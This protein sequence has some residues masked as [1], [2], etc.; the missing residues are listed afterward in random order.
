MKLDRDI[1][2]DKTGKYM[3]IKQRE[4]RALDPEDYLAAESALDVLRDLGVLDDSRTGD[5][6]E[7]FVMRLKDKYTYR[8]LMGYLKAIELEEPMDG[9]YAD[10]ILDMAQRAG[11]NSP[12]CKLPD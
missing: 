8:G 1:N 4:L 7:F 6:G 5:E 3:L 10:A 12:F 11:V 2:A 9:E